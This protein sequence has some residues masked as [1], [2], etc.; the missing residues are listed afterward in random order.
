MWHFNHLWIRKHKWKCVITTSTKNFR[1]PSQKLPT[2]SV[3]ILWS[4][5]KQEN[6]NLLPLS[7]GCADNYPYKLN[8]P[9]IF[10]IKCTSFLYECCIIIKKNYI[11]WRI[12]QQS[13]KWLNNPDIY[14]QFI[15]LKKQ[16]CSNFWQDWVE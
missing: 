4:E 9:L 14:V 10:A 3:H 6:P 11:C 15:C 5:Y 7:T 16:M 13:F 2:N 12:P 1:F 8:I